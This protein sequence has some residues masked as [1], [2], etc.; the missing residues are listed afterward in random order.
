MQAAVLGA[1]LPLLDAANAKRRMHATAYTRLLTGVGD[2]VMPQVPADCEPVWHFFVVQTAHRDALLKH[3]ADNKVEAG[4]HYPI[5][6]HRQEAYVE[7]KAYDGKLPVCEA[8]AP[9]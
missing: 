6:I 2:L 1:K 8:A 4:I 5:P 7:L 9:R 3:L